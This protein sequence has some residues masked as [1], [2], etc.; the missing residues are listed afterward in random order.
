MGSG[1]TSPSFYQRLNRGPRTWSTTNLITNHLHFAD[2]LPYLRK[3][4]E[5]SNAAR[6]VHDL[7]ISVWFQCTCVGKKEQK[8]CIKVWLGALVQPFFPQQSIFRY[9]YFMLYWYYPGRLINYL[10]H[11][12]LFVQHIRPCRMLR[13][14]RNSWWVHHYLAL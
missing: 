12:F 7:I 6:V 10:V 3:I 5:E 14:W 9:F 13:P 4:K 8:Q 2:T 1:T 11:T